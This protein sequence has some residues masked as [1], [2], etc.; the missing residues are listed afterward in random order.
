MPNGPR[1]IEQLSCLSAACYGSSFREVWERAITFGIT[2]LGLFGVWDYSPKAVPAP[3]ARASACSSVFSEDMGLSVLLP[4]TYSCAHKRNR[5]RRWCRCVLECGVLGLVRVRV[6]L[7]SRPIGRGGSRGLAGHARARAAK[8][9]CFLETIQTRADFGLHAGN[10]EEPGEEIRRRA[11]APAHARLLTRP[12]RWP[13]P[14]W[15][16][17]RRACR[18]DNQRSERC[19]RPRLWC[20]CVLS[21]A[22]G[23]GAGACRSGPGVGGGGGPGRR[24]CCRSRE[25]ACSSDALAPRMLN[26]GGLLNGTHGSSNELHVLCSKIR[27]LHVHVFVFVL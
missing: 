24:S 16:D 14:P 12:T 11:C 15:M 23:A 5:P 20:W 4:R 18:G 17:S 3:A 19:T 22:F 13:K 9:K 6:D 21:A 27:V 1:A 8:L 10:R 2:A 26:T 25:R 7:E